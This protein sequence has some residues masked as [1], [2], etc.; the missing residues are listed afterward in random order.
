[1]G[2]LMKFENKV[3]GLHF[4]TFASGEYSDY[5]VNSIA[6]CDHPV[7]QE[8]WY[9]HLKQYRQ[10]F[11]AKRAELSQKYNIDRPYYVYESEAYKEF[12]IWQAEND[13]DV[14]F[15]KKHC[16]IFVEYQECHKDD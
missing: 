8:D 7:S 9:E 5:G 14:T 11:E 12:E 2:V 16:M 10:D 3:K 6:V 1:M 4:F 15:S 13:P